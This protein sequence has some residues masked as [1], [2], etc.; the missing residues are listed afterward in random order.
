V[1]EQMA[2]DGDDKAALVLEAMAYGVAKSIGQLAVVRGGDV[3]QIVLTGGVAYSKRITD[4]IV[5][6]LSF[7]APVTILP[8][9]KEMEALAAGALRVLNGEE[10]INPYDIYPPGYSSIKEIIRNPNHLA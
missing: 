9:E 1:V 10:E 7:I 6:K 2:A 4:Y 3:D 8:G 5:D